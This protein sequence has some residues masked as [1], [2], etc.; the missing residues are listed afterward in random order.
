MDRL[1]RAARIGVMLLVG[2][3]PGAYGQSS[4]APLPGTEL[5]TIDKPLDEVMV[6]GINRFALR[7][8]QQSPPQRDARWARDYASADAYLKSVEPNRDRL[9]TI[10]GAVDRRE[11]AHGFELITTFGHDGVVARSAN[12]A[13]YAVRWPVLTGVT[14]EGLLLQPHDPPV[15]RV[16]ALPDADWTPEALA[17][18]AAEIKDCHPLAG[19]L[20]ANGIQVIVP[21]LIS[22]DDAYSGSPLVAYTNQPHR[23]FI[24][25]QAFEMGRHIIGYEV[26]KVQAAVDELEQLNRRD[27]V[28][29]P[30]GV[31]G[32][33]EGGLLAFYAAAIDPRIDAT[34]ASGYFRTRERIWEEP[35]YRNVWA[36]LTEFGDAEIASL[37]APRPLIIE[38]CAVPEIV[39]PR[40]PHDGRRGGAAP[41]KIETCPLAEV[42]TEFERARKHYDQLK[43]TDGI[44]LVESEQGMG[45]CGSEPAL[46]AFLRG[47]GVDR[48]RPAALGM[49]ELTEEQV[50]PA[51]RQ[52][53]QVQELI[54][55]TQRLMRH[56]AKVRDD[57]WSKADRSSVENWVRSVEYYRNY[58]WEEMIG[59]LPPPTM[60]PNVRTR[61]VLDD[62]AYTGYEVVIDV[63]P[64]VIAAGILLLPKNLEAAE[65]RPVVVCQ[66]GLEGVPRDTITRSGEAYQYYKSFAA[67]LATRGFIV[68]APQNPYRGSDRFRVIQRQSNPMKRS[69]FSYIVRQHERTLEWLATLPN[70]DPKRIAFYGLS[71]GGKTTM[72]VPPMLGE[73]YAACICSG[74]FNEWIRKNASVDDSYSYMFTGEYEMPE[75]NMGHIANYAELASLMTPRPFMVERGH[76]DGVAPDEWVAEEYSKT[77]RHYVKFGL[78]DQTEIEFFDGPH[79]IHGVNT[80]RFLHQHLDWPEAPFPNRQLR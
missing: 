69:L 12:F 80:Y 49:L 45:P 77:R 74:D 38:A 1:K 55:Y 31:V 67:E 15:A 51:E 54:D 58:V 16:V 63:Y 24:Y 56:S 18:M 66:H 28:D 53:R 17:G 9:R 32:V 20:A 33:G 41:G 43:S 72:R 19:R 11:A 50:N 70:V 35:I 13:V 59:K 78:G 22:R 37:I 7:A 42:R 14:A 36:L 3:A 25:R 23:E 10:I 44:S 39:G 57:F 5:L 47:L 27:N 60:P 75:W 65:K 48:G 68:Y 79:T 62:P 8:L 2:F 71:Y 34:M 61:A 30:I 73:M 21:M 40:P 4:S 76:D 52:R 6:A 64:D 26:E 29:A 46:I